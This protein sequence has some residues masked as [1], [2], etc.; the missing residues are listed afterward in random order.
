M[1]RRSFLKGAAALAAAP[2]LPAVAEAAPI[3]SAAIAESAATVARYRNCI[4]YCLN[5]FKVY[6]AAGDLRIVMGDSDDPSGVTLAHGARD[7]DLGPTQ[8]V[9]EGSRSVG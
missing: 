4:V 8:F 1:L 6:D 5:G 9:I 3:E 2:L 7:R